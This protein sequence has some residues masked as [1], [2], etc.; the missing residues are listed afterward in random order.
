MNSK[1]K[2]LLCGI[3]MFLILSIGFKASCIEYSQILDDMDVLV[4]N[5]FDDQDRLLTEDYVEISKAYWA[6]EIIEIMTE[7]KLVTHWMDHVLADPTTV[8]WIF[9]QSF[10][11]TL[12]KYPVLESTLRDPG[13]KQNMKHMLEI[14]E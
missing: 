4:S 8:L 12:K 11:N 14:T 13:V 10:E 9:N 2:K 6:M 7:Q 3:V 1:F 5:V